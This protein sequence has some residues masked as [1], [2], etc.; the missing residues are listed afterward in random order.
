MDANAFRR[1]GVNIQFVWFA[2]L[3]QF[4]SIDFQEWGCLRTEIRSLARGV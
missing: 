3:R 2:H 1:S 4:A